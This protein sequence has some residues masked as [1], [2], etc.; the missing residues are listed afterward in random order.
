MLLLLHSL[1]HHILPP[2]F[3]P[4]S[5]CG[6]GAFICSRDR[7][8]EGWVFNGVEE[9]K[10]W[11]RLGERIGIFSCSPDQPLPNVFMC[12]WSTLPEKPTTI[13][14]V[15]LTSISQSR[16]SFLL[17]IAESLLPWPSECWWMELER[18]P[19]GDR[20]FLGPKC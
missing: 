19:T 11:R 17:T 12:P 9:E 13:S 7:V 20:C 4:W 1:P 2:S 15:P 18:I 14:P 3:L 5:W 6:K 8:V 16:S 10:H